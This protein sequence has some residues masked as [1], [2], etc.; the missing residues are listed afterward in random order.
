[1]LVRLRYCPSMERR[2]WITAAVAASVLLS[3][4][5]EGH[6]AEGPSG[7][8]PTMTSSSTPHAGPETSKP[9]DSGELPSTA[10]AT[11]EPGQTGRLTPALGALNSVL[12][13]IATDPS[14]EAR[15][16]SA[17]T[18]FFGTEADVSSAIGM[19]VVLNSAGALT[20]TKPPAEDLSKP[21]LQD[22]SLFCA[23]GD[24]SA[25]EARLTRRKE[26]RSLTPGQIADD[27]DRQALDGWGVM[28]A[29]APSQWTDQPPEGNIFYS[30]K[31]HAKWP[32]NWA[33]QIS[34]DGVTVG[35]RANNMSAAQYGN[36][37]K[38]RGQGIDA[39][40]TKLRDA[41]L[42]NLAK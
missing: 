18:K 11:L 22:W 38:A 7:T 1:M 9:T 14:D 8:T 2:T 34:R 27:V 3:G 19:D 35:C 16:R 39:R 13:N 4:C 31:K 42:A 12:R 25:P 40:A 21:E 17:C 24:R 32:D 36:T 33:R 5:S 10:D 6:D 15:G 30:A 37:S 29:V 28:C 26:N 41:G 20:L 23:W